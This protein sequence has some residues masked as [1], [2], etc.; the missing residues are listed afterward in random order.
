M[1][2]EQLTIS[3]YEK[4]ERERERERDRQRL[5]MRIVKPPRAKGLCTIT[6]KSSAEQ[7]TRSHTNSEFTVY[8]VGV[9]KC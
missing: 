2:S 3:N 6:G 1:Y 7:P 8:K 9:G 5:Q 4:R